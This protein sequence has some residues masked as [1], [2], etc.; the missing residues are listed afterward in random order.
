MIDP[1]RK[2]DPIVIATLGDLI[3]ARMDLLVYCGRGLGAHPCGRK[4][5]VG[6]RQLAELFGREESYVAARFPLKCARCGSRDLE[7]RV[8][9]DTTIAPSSPDP[10]ARR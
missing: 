3:D 8:Q 5:D 2:S 6:A 7:Y 10:F 1:T 9:A 4:L